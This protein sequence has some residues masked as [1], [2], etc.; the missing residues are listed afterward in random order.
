ML[1]ARFVKSTT[2]TAHNSTCLEASRKPA[3][4]EHYL[5][6]LSKHSLSEGRNPSL[7][8]TELAK[9]KADIFQNQLNLGFNGSY[10]KW[11]EARVALNTKDTNTKDT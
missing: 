9:A 8:H 10:E 2:V 6:T 3:S 11:R 5:D 4:N 7:S 1:A